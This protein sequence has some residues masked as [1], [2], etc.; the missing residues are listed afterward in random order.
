MRTGRPRKS[1]IHYADIAPRSAIIHSD[2]IDVELV[3]AFSYAT[4]S[5]PGADGI[6]Q[7]FHDFEDFWNFREHLLA[8]S[9]GLIIAPVEGKLN[10]D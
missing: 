1:R 4:Q 10:N 5:F 8:A 2:P 3:E 7:A 6:H 9:A